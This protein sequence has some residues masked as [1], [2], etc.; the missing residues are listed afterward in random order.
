MPAGSVS[1]TARNMHQQMVTM[2]QTGNE[3][4]TIMLH[5]LHFELANLV[6]SR[7]TVAEELPF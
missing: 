2:P 1:Q 6:T 7:S 3:G 4:L 5:R